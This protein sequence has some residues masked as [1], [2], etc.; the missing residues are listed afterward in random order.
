[1]ERRASL[2]IWETDRL[3]VYIYKSKETDKFLV[4]VWQVVCV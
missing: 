3:S 1:M 2:S 4:L